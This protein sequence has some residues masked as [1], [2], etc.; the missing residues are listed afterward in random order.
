MDIWIYKNYMDK[1]NK[2]QN[3]YNTLNMIWHEKNMNM[4]H[5]YEFSSQILP[6]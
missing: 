5:I 6:L 3:L 4:T 1:K 2:Y